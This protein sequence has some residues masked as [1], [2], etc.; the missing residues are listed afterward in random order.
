MTVKELYKRMCEA[1]PDELREPWD[2]DGLM[3][4]PDAEHNVRRV[5]LTLDVTAEIIDTVIAGASKT[6]VS[7]ACCPVTD[8]VKYVDTERHSIYTPKRDYLLAIQTPQVFAKTAFT[9]AY[10][11][12]IKT[13]G[14]FT[15]E[16]SMLENAGAKVKYVQTSPK[17]IKLTTKEDILLAKAMLL[18]E[19]AMEDKHD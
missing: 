6:G 13:G 3:C 1:L 14:S 18:V 4:C 5:I 7:T 15:D 8:T 11:L 2:N 10:A 17:N 19:K 9:A 16:T 12:A